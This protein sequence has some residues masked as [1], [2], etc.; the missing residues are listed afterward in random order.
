MKPATKTAIFAAGAVLALAA[1]GVV[2]G[3]AASAAED[4][5][6]PPPIACVALASAPVPNPAALARVWP[7][8]AG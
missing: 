2:A 7:S 6:P 1:I 3:L 8:S 4:G 5:P